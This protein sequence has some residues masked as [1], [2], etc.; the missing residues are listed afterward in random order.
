MLLFKVQE[1]LID[2]NSKLFGGMDLQIADYA[3]MLISAF[4]SKEGAEML[5]SFLGVESGG[6]KGLGVDVGT[7]DLQLDS[8]DGKLNI[9]CAGGT[10]AGSPNAMR[11]AA[12]LA[13]I[14][15]PTRYNQLFE[16]PHKDGQFYDRLQVMRAIIDWADQDTVTFGTSSVEDYRYEV[17]EDPYTIKN[18]YYD[19][20]EE[21]R[22]VKGI[23]D[24]F[25]AAFKESL[26]VYGECKV[27]VNLASLP[28]LTALIIQH[29]QKQNDPALQWENLA[30]LARYILRIRE[31]R[32]G[33]P[34][35]KSFIN[36]VQ[37]PVAA[38]Q[39]SLIGA[40]IDGQEEKKRFNLPMVQ[41]L[42]LNEKTLNDAVVVGGPRR[43]WRIIASAKVGRIKKKIEAV[44]DMKLVSSY[45][46]SRGT[47]G[48]LYWR[49]E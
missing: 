13:A 38:M 11:V 41:G 15:L 31:N 44:W 4:N 5:G 7:F 29:A 25:M 26:T 1:Q 21:L 36:A 3:P 32:M 35:V 42:Q 22:L 30:M 8:L 49:E 16:H 39:A 14:M 6:I 28:V 48:F 46:R 18:H 37:E 12:G 24:N 40:Q 20:L 10:N 34:D 33:F 45:R 17:G 9:N 23:N 27:N 43:I 19:T 47:G 2:K